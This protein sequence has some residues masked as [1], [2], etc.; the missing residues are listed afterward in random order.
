M[1]D[2]MIIIII[3]ISKVNLKPLNVNLPNRIRLTVFLKQSE[4]KS[5][6]MI[7]ITLL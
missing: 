1:F 6:A 4:I 5:I 2:A 3:I 7:I